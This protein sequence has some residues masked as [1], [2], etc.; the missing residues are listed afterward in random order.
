VT[1]A[2][3]PARRSDGPSFDAFERARAGLP[4]ELAVEFFFELP[5]EAQDGCWR[6]LGVACADHREKA[7]AADPDKV[8]WR[9][10]PRVGRLWDTRASAQ[11]PSCY[12]RSRVT[13][14]TDQHRD[15]PLVDLAPAVYVEALTGE[16][17]SPHGTIRCPLP[18][19]ADRW[20]SFKVY[21]SPA[22]GWYCFGCG[23][24]GSIFDLGAALWGLHTRGEDFKEL[25]RRLSRHLLR[26]AA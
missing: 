7:R 4:D 1:R 18:D 12:A 3:Q 16:A 6:Q 2:M 20:P 26:E 8:L 19:H 14:R 13:G 9:H 21:E 10:R 15:D 25:H 24:G 11:P 17:V 23:R 5:A 22:E